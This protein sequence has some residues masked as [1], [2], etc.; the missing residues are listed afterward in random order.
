VE[1]TPKLIHQLHQFAFVIDHNDQMAVCEVA[2]WFVNAFSKK[3]DLAKLERILEGYI[4]DDGYMGSELVNIF[5]AT[6]WPNNL[7]G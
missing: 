2:C 3:G 6:I 1:I 4:R 7:G 5:Q